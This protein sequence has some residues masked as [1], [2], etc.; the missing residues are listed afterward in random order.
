MGGTKWKPELP[1]AEKMNSLIEEYQNSLSTNATDTI[2][3]FMM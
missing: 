1:T 3:T 2:L